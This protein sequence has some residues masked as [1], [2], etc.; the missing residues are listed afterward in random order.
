VPRSEHASRVSQVAGRGRD[1][2]GLEAE[3]VEGSEVGAVRVRGTRAGLPPVEGRVA[4]E[5][6]EGREGAVGAVHAPV[7]RILCRTIREQEK[8]AAEAE[9]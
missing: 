4:G 2:R 1:V 8:S 5:L 6:V 7:V 3:L 9:R